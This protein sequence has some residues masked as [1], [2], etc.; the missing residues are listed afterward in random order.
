MAAGF[1]AR[2][3]LGIQL[4]QS[5]YFK[6]VGMSMLGFTSTKTSL[7]F[8]GN[9]SGSV[10]GGLVTYCLDRKNQAVVSNNLIEH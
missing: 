6:S 7:P 8:A 5:S 9:R 3:H 4:E 1:K 10:C 2:K